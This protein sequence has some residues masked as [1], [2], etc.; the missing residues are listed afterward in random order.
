MT[1]E[2]MITN[3][4]LINSTHKLKFLIIKRL[5]FCTTFPLKLGRKEIELFSE[6]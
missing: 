2:Q 6:A 4:Q 3:E 5:K 1:Q